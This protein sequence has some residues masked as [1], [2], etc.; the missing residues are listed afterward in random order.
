MGKNP[1]PEFFVSLAVPDL[2]KSLRI[3][4][5]HH[6]SRILIKAA[7]YHLSIPGDDAA[8]PHAEASV[9]QLI[10]DLK[11]RVCGGVVVWWCGVMTL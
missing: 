2:P 4:I 6:I 3:Q 7:R 10:L 9:S 11:Y 1:F 5:P 8:A